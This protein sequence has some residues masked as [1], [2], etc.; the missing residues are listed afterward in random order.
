M[1][2]RDR[3]RD[4]PEFWEDKLKILKSKPG[5]TFP[6]DRK[7]RREKIYPVI[8]CR[9]EIPCD[10]CVTVCPKKSIKL[11]ESSIMS[12]PYFEGECIG[13]LKC[14]IVCPGLAITVV[15]RRK[16]PNE[17]FV[18]IPLEM[19]R[20]LVETADKLESVDEEGNPLGKCEV[21]K[22]INQ[23]SENMLILQ[24]KAKGDIADKIVSVRLF[25]AKGHLQ[26]KESF[27]DENP[28]ICRCE[29]VREK[30][31]RKILEEGITD[32][33]QIKALTRAAMGACGGK[34]CTE[35]VYRVFREMGIEP[36]EI[37][38]GTIRPFAQEVPLDAF[39]G[40]GRE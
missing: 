8:H 32:L 39:L 13:C 23:E 14:L 22:V 28:V 31:I 6:P 34:T 17:P 16:N 3:T 38:P 27:A 35:L 4:V 10:P 25:R 15:D 30:E 1:C 11:R 7:K 5:R 33:N 40:D 36:G 24:L 37:E 29:R 21:A 19:S 2:I 18:Y 9:Q 26:A 20:D 12:L